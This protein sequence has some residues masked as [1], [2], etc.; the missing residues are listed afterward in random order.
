MKINWSM[1]A[2]VLGL[3]LNF[4]GVAYWG[5]SIRSDVEAL[6]TSVKAETVQQRVEHTEFRAQISV[7]QQR[8]SRVEGRL[9][10]PSE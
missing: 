2:V 7:L 8:T 5:G 6:D 9:N 1:I 4:A 10:G 3:I